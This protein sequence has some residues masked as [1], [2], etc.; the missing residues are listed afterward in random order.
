MSKFFD[1]LGDDLSDI[2]NSPVKGADAKA[3]PATYAPKDFSEPC[4]KCKGRGRFV[5]Y[6]GRDVG[7]CYAC[8]GEGKKTFKSSSADRAKNREQAA[9]RATA[10]KADALLTFAAEQPAAWDWIQ[11]NALKPVPFAFAV[12]MMED[13]A[14]YGS[15]SQGKLDAI[16]RMI[17][18]EEARKEAREAAA[19]ERKASA[20]SIDVMKIETAFAVAREKASRPGQLGTFTKPLK[21]TAPNK[22]TLS[23]FPGSIGSQWEGMLFVKAEDGRKLGYIK[24]GKLFARRENTNEENAAILAA[25]ADPET[26]VVAY[27]KAFSRCGVCGHQLLNDVSIARGIGPICAEKFGW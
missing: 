20:P 24:G 3:P 8:K 12:S 17:A 6:S 11:E 16:H 26:A 15:L 4:P 21:L 27:A 23:F 5:S 19:A 10:K 25:A 22:V 14:K 13:I 7:P 1:G 2:I 18:R 9:A